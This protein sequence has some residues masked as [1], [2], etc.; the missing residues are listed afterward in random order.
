MSFETLP[1]G[2]KEE[3][4]NY[5]D[6]REYY[7]M[8]LVSNEWRNSLEN[9]KSLI[10]KEKFKNANDT[11]EKWK[12]GRKFYRGCCLTS[13]ILSSINSQVGLKCCYGTV[14]RCR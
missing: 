6:E 3:I 12:H 9:P 2:I 10:L 5:L 13:K 14:Y 11:K 4:W 1:R 7:K 8:R